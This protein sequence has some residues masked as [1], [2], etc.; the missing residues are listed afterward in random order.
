MKKLFSALLVLALL[1]VAS[2]SGAAPNA[3]RIE[4]GTN[5]GQFAIRPG[6]AYVDARVLAANVSE[7][8]TIPT[9]ALW[10][11][12]SSTCNFYAKLGASAAIPAADVTDGTGS[13]LNPA[14]WQISGSTQ[15]TLI[16][17]TACTVTMAFYG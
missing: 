13:E 16:S 8:H 1:A 2:V 6:P 11:L 5:G 17:A 4:V 10:V 9:G 15:I 14:A 3:F 7:T 12:F